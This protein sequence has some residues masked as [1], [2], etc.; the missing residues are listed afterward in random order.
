M[1]GEQFVGDCEGVLG[2]SEVTASDAA[3]R[4]PVRGRGFRYGPGRKTAN[5]LVALFHTQRTGADSTRLM[6]AALVSVSFAGN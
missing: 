5:L 1:C 2:V 3:V 6:I 4:E